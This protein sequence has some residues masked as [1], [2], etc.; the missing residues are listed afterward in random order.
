MAV[1]SE[2]RLRSVEK[3]V[4]GSGTPKAFGSILFIPGKRAGP[5]LAVDGD[6]LHV[7][8][9]AGEHAL[10][11]ALEPGRAGHPH[12]SPAVT[13]A[14]FGTPKAS[15]EVD[16]GRLVN[17]RLGRREKRWARRVGPER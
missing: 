16:R 13:P 3:S 14:S 10:E 6:D 8:G 7:G 11:R 17:L 12:P 9:E 5:H 15:T 1:S 4:A 2:D